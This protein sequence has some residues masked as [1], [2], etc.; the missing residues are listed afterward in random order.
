M[1]RFELMGTLTLDGTH[2]AETSF[3]FY[4]NLLKVDPLKK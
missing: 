1:R 3:T 2:L 4:N